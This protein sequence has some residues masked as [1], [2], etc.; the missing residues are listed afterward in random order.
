MIN[1]IP[2][3]NEHYHTFQKQDNWEQSDLCFL[4]KME[5]DVRG[6]FGELLISRWLHKIPDCI[7]EQD[8]SDNSKHDDGHY[9]LKACGQRIEVKTSCLSTNCWQHEPLYK[10]NACDIVFFLDFSYNNMC[11]FS[12]VRSIDLPLGRDSDIMPGKH[13]TLRKNKDDG[14]KLDFSFKTL[15]DLAK[16]NKMLSFN[17]SSVDEE[18]VLDFIIRE[19]MNNV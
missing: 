9:D 13:G 12:I 5:N 14:Y 6:K 2:D 1:L 8:V 18:Q 19:L 16:V 7:M 17:V 10:E 15:S 11:Y 3:I 4:K